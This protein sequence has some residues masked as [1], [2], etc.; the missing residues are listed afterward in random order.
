MKTIAISAGEN[1]SVIRSI[2]VSAKRL[3]IAEI[4][5]IVLVFVAGALIF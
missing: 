4:V 1:G 5:S 3:I 2:T